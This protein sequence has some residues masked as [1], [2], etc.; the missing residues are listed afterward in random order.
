MKPHL[1]ILLLFALASALSPSAAAAQSTY[2]AVV[3]VATDAS[4]GVLPGATVTLT[5][6]LTGVAR[7]A[8][9][10]ENGSY[11]FFNLTQG[12]YVVT[13]ELGGFAGYSTEP[14]RVEARQTVRINAHS[15]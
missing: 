7:T 15:R 4:M 1:H 9:T 12:L 11:E 13:M 10:K 2:G 6:V 3:G 14:F 8:T 5:E